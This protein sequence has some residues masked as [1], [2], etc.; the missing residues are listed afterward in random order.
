MWEEI[1]QFRKKW[2]NPKSDDEWEQATREAI[3]FG[4]KWKGLGQ[5]MIV[6]LLDYMAEKSRECE[7]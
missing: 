7:T 4:N 6:A 3:E 5:K 2:Y 1:F